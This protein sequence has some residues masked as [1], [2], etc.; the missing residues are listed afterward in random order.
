L[1]QVDVVF[2]VHMICDLLSLFC[3]RAACG[4]E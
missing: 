1:K 4:G 3:F 2:V